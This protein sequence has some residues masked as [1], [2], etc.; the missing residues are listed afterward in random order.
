MT[1]EQVIKRINE[2]REILADYRELTGYDH[3]ALDIAISALSKQCAR[4]E[5]ADQCGNNTEMV[6][7][8]RDTT[9][10]TDDVLINLPS[11]QP[12]TNCSEIPNNSDLI[13]RQAVID[14]LKDKDPSQIWD[15]ADI[16]VWINSLP[17]A[18]PEIN[19]D[20]DTISRQA[21][22]GVIKAISNLDEKTK[23]GI[24][25]TFLLLDSAQPEPKT[26]WDVISRQAAIDALKNRW[27]KT[28]NY[29]GIG[30]DI[31]EECEL[32][33]K[34]LPL[35]QPEIKTDGD[36]ISRQQTIDALMQEFKRIPTNS[37]R[38]KLVVE[39][40]PS[41]QPERKTGRWIR[42]SN[43]LVPYYC[44]SC[45]G[46]FNYEWNFCPNCGA[47]MLKEGENIDS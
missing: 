21:A 33:L 45:T 22:I 24:I 39:N 2:I 10:K 3:E 5:Q 34:Q 23:G 12:E 43:K 7:Q 17:S 44:S 16:E 14:D 46:R 15:T 35:A 28:R 25:A 40:L 26:R 27:K 19:T 36:T 38:A 31:A 8:F 18:Q 30:D 37:I 20:G 29:E 1:N 9:K 11:A 4:G 42:S 6:D 47:K 32:Y 41:A 13:S